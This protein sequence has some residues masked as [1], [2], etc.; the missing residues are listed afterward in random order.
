M[1]TDD[2]DRKLTMRL[3]ADQVP[4]RHH[5]QPQTA[6]IQTIGRSDASVWRVRT[7][8]RGPGGQQSKDRAAKRAP[9]RCG[10]CLGRHA[11]GCEEEANWYKTANRLLHF[12]PE[13]EGEN[14]G[15][16]IGKFMIEK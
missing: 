13:A 16:P 4:E 14:G 9:R 8:A 12:I 2:P 11:E 6:S 3:S 15:C 5:S 1:G 7:G 10:L